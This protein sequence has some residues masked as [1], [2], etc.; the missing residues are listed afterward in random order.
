MVKLLLKSKD[1][2]CQVSSYFG[3]VNMIYKS[4]SDTGQKSPPSLSKVRKGPSGIGLSP[5]TSF[6][7]T[8]IL[9]WLY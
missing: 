9:N 6:Q 1:M 4:F 5:L 3:E 2:L 8:C 7:A